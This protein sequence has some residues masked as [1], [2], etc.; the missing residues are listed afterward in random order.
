MRWGCL[1]FILLPSVVEA[2]VTIHEVAWMG[3]AT[4]ANYEWI[5][6]HNDG[7]AT[8][9]DG[10]VLSDG[11][12]L[13]ITLSGTIPQNSYAVL[14]R[15]TD[16][17]APGTAFLLYSGALVNSGATLSLRRSDGFLEDQVAGGDAWQ[18]IGGDNTTKETAQYTSAGWVT[19]KATPGKANEEKTTTKE[20]QTNTSNTSDTST[21]NRNTTSAVKRSEPDEPKSLELLPS[22]LELAVTAPETGYVNQE[23]VFSADASGI[24]TTLTNSLSYEWNFGDGMTDGG[25][26][27]SHRFQFPGTYVVMVY[28][29]YKRQ[30]QV[31]RHEIT[32]LPVTLSLSRNRTGDLQINNNAQYEVD[33]SGFTIQGSKSFTFAEH[34]IVLPLQT[35]TLHAYD[36][37]GNATLYDETG[38]YIASETT[39]APAVA[40]AAATPQPLAR[41][42]TYSAPTFTKLPTSENSDIL[43]QTEATTSQPTVISINQESRNP[44][45]ATPTANNN[46]W[47]YAALAGLLVLGIGGVVYRRV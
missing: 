3:N 38:A 43:N 8:P 33:I 22:S 35:I 45:Q 18:N 19:A 39:A 10:W 40:T 2:A 27:V 12:N 1:V 44:N 21:S 23:I 14:E 28:G 36:I 6:L 41:S 16:D 42:T 32:I 15:S 25:E 7:A 24:G 31:A 13:S 4:S 20:T 5:E 47:P 11:K 46:R 34:S 29:H 26:E 9:L 17:S 30:E 37:G